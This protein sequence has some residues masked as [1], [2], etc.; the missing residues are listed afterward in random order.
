[1][2]KKSLIR[3][4]ILVCDLLLDPSPVIRRAV[5]GRPELGW[6]LLMEAFCLRDTSKSERREDTL[7]Y[8]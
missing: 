5:R 3:A 6:G 7:E 1:M 8:P 2:K 4:G